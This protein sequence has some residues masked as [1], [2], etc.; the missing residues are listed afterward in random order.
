MVIG[1]LAHVDA[2]KTTLSE[3]ILYHTGSIRKMGRVDHGDAFLDTDRIEKERG[4]TIYSKEA[5][6]SLEERKVYMLDTP[7]HIDFSPEMERTLQVLDY[8]ILVINGADGVQSHTGTLW[9][10]LSIYNIPVF[11]FINKMDQP[12][13]DKAVLMKDLRKLCGDGAV[14]FS[15]VHD[16]ETMEE[17]AVSKE[18]ILE[19]F[20][21]Y[22]KI[23]KEHIAEAVG[24]R[25]IF[26]CYFGSALKD[27]GVK[28]FLDDFGKYTMEKSYGNRFLARVFKIS[29]DSHGAR[30]TYMKITGGSLKV[31][32]VIRG[33]EGEKWQEKAEQIRIYSGDKFEAVG[34]AQAGTVC[35]V[36]GLTKTYSGE[37]L[38]E[39]SSENN[40]NL[41]PP[42]LEPVLMYRILFP[43]G[44]DIHG[45][46]R[47]LRQLQEEE[48]QLH[49]LWNEKTSEIYVKVMGPVQIE[50]LKSII[51][52]RYQTDAEFDSGNIVYKETIKNTV[53]GV[54][55]FE[56]LRHYAEVHLILEPLPVGSGLV[57]E[58]MCSED[59]L[60]KNWQR[61]I[62]THL[63]E[64]EH[65]GVLTG[66]PITDMRITLTAGKAHKKHT[67]GG[68]FRQATYRAVR[69]GLKEAE[70]ILL[71]PYYDFRME[72]PANTL[73]RAMTDIQN[74]KGTFDNPENDGEMAVITGKCPVSSMSD[75]PAQV[76]SYTK[77]RGRIYCTVKGYE[78]CHNQE[79]IVKNIGY[80][81]EAD[82][83]NPTGSMFCGHGAGYYVPWYQVKSHMHMESTIEKAKESHET[84]NVK[85]QKACENN[86]YYAGEKE[87]QEIF[88]RTYGKKFREKE[89][90]PYKKTV[91]HNTVNDNANK[92]YVYK[93]TD[94][95]MEE[96]LLVDGYNI[97]FAWE[98]LNSLSK[99][100][101]EGAR[102]RL[103]EILCNYQG[104]TK[105]N[106]IL[107]FD[108]YK[109]QGN[110]GS[111]EKYKN[112][113]VVYTREAETADQYIEKTVHN[114]GKKHR[115][116]VATSDRLE[117]MIIMGDGAVRMSAEGFKK[118][119]EQINQNIRNYLTN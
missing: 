37:L 31:K 56:P 48:P 50:I 61:L 9:R 78:P 110:K 19:Y 55:H 81:S 98:E 88:E 13:T 57:F 59:I 21:E 11:I 51:R 60:D 112:I 79:E 29:R 107:V 118:E 17:I 70:T 75:Y 1:I 5:V 96:Y 101:M 62:L 40:I 6:F 33:G 26:P 45:M 106:L 83:E 38:G 46:L 68:D 12:G 97:I 99:S 23:T 44:T 82:L 43:K 52:D 10:L 15:D 27:M 16:R 72:I 77:G 67:E 4:I 30:L 103:Q 90:N 53:E 65:I 35:A 89:K 94:K 93:G 25:K 58:T 91:S 2:G 8:A 49:I 92:E 108:A 36:T 113:Y 73:G 87:L 14:D 24:E 3:S 115:V 34:E 47:N 39:L 116:T 71:E 18:N 64:K 7:G 86:D 114:I 41:R 95:N 63:K 22:G 85:R 66:S 76:V 111:I 119:V 69:Q 84:I 105:C 117:Q 28:E 102:T 100:N 109:V 104:Y 32:D 20:M 42:V 80:D 74:M 54:G